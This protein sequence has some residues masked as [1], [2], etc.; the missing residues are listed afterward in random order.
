MQA[1]EKK[2]FKRS[3]IS[4]KNKLHLIMQGANKEWKVVRKQ[5]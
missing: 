1:K 5:I 4:Y 3:T 2:N